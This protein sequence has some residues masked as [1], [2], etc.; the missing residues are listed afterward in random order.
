MCQ[1]DLDKT[2]TE[3]DIYELTGN[4]Y[5]DDPNNSTTD[6]ELSFFSSTAASDLLMHKDEPSGFYS[7]KYAKLAN[8]TFEDSIRLTKCCTFKY[9]EYLEKRSKNSTI[10]DEI[11]DI[12]LGTVELF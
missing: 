6:N 10:L 12:I 7:K 2:Q 4:N 3:L 5:C 9:D 1:Y 8:K 11:L